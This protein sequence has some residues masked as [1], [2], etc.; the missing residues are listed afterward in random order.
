MSGLEQL[1]Q[2]GDQSGCA[3]DLA[4]LQAENDRLRAELAA[5]RERAS[6]FKWVIKRQRQALQAPARR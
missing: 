2:G 4:S 3:R 6:H 1:R 5:C